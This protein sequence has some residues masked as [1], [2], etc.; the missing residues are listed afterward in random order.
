MLGVVDRTIP[1]RRVPPKHKLWAPRRHQELGAQ[2][3]VEHACAALFFSPGLGKTSCTL[4]A[5]MNLAKQGVAQRMLIIAPLRVCQSVWRQEAQKWTQFRELRFSLLHGKDKEKNLRVDADIF[6]INPEGLDWLCGLYPPGINLPFDTLCIDELTKFKNAQGKRFKKLRARTRKC[7]RRWG[8]TGTPAANGYEDL[9]GQ[10]LILDEGASL[11]R[12][13]THYRE[14]YFQPSYDGFNWTLRKGSKQKILKRIAPYVLHMRTKDCVD[15]PPV[16]DHIHHIEM[17]DKAW[18]YYKDMEEKMLAQMTDGSVEAASAGAVYTKLRQMANGSVYSQGL[19]DENRKTLKVH[20]EKVNALEDLIEELGGEQLLVAYEFQHDLAMIRE[21]LGRD[22]PHLG[23]GVSEK[24]SNEIIAA[25][26]RGDIPVLL[27]HPKSAGHGLNLQESSAWNVCW[28][29]PTWNLEEYEQFIDR[30]CRSGNE[31]EKIVNH[32]L[33]VKGTID[34]IVLQALS[35]KDMTQKEL[36][37]ALVTE[38]HPQVAG[39][40]A[41]Q[42]NEETNMVKK[43]RGKTGSVW[44]KKPETEDDISTEEAEQ[45]EQGTEEAETKSA[46][47][48]GWGGGSKSSSGTT[49]QKKTLRKKLGPKKPDPADEEDDDGEE[50][51]GAMDAFSD[52]IQKAFGEGGVPDEIE[53]ENNEVGTVS[54]E[55]EQD[56]ESGEED[57]KKQES[58]KAPVKPRETRSRKPA[59]KGAGNTDSGLTKAAGAAPVDYDHLADVLLGRVATK[60]APELDMEA[61]AVSLLKKMGERLQG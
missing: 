37:N 55:E 15:V 61:L 51:S 58:E 29:T 2:F 38:L 1:T 19:D 47:P 28:F 43:L 54:E 24:K 34:E 9:F 42:S 18:K 60:T 23:K 14:R 48:K 7:A 27:A 40:V 4:S 45:E 41:A 12:Y 6:L 17:P 5:F 52:S 49:E 16:T 8:L 21:R 11:G 56:T 25:W 39:D 50:Q 57:A 53:E 30:I 36:L 22:I 3:L 46:A 44:G 26:N 31:A 35:H 33:V 13:I 10:M 59:T 32:L 20:D